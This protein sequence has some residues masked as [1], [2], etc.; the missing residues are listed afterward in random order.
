MSADPELAPAPSFLD[1]YK[2][3]SAQP[4]WPDKLRDLKGIRKRHSVGL[5]KPAQCPVLAWFGHAE[6]ARR[7][8]PPS[9]HE[10]EAR[11]YPG[12]PLVRFAADLHWIARM[13]PK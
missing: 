2:E 12:L 7:G 13:K 4:D 9:M 8:L 6:L 5:L 1:L 10:L 11:D 3:A